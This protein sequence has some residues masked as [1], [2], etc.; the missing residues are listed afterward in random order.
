MQNRPNNQSS[1]FLSGLSDFFLGQPARI[2]QFSPYSQSQQNIF[3]LLGQLG[4]SQL[5][6][7]YQG[8]EP[9]QQQAMNQFQ[10]EIVP[11]LA[12]RFTSL[13]NNRLSSGAFASQLGQA[14][15]GLQGNL[16]ALKS[17]YG[18]QN[19]NQALQTLGLGL[20]PQYQ[21]QFMQGQPGA[22]AQGGSALLRLLPFLL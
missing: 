13:G 14:G 12:E 3:D 7:P 22:L 17:Q 11:T 18:M 20:T 6:N 21:N 10:Q 15:A 9:I 1:G 2:E 5:Q 16:A 8:F 4:L 19:R